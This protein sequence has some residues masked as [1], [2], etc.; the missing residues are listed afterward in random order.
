MR[1]QEEE[2][3][4]ADATKAKEEVAARLAAAQ[5]RGETPYP[6]SKGRQARNHELSSSKHVDLIFTHRL[7]ACVCLN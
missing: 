5:V 4:A 2:R 1:A 6:T 3:N 7:C